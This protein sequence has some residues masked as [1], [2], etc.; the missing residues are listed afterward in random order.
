MAKQKNPLR[1]TGLAF[2]SKARLKHVAECALAVKLD[3]AAQSP[4]MSGDELDAAV[5]GDFHV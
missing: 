2:G 4:R 5:N 3:A 1:G